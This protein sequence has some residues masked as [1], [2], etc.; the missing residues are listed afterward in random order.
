MLVR[1][2]AGDEELPRWRG[3]LPLARRTTAGG[4]ELLCWRRLGAGEA[5]DLPLAVRSTAGDEELPR[6]RRGRPLARRTVVGG[7]EL[8]RWIE[9]GEASSEG[10]ALLAEVAATSCL[11]SSSRVSNGC[12][13]LLKGSSD[14]AAAE[15][16]VEDPL[17][18]GAGGAEPVDEDGEA[19][20]AS[21]R[22]DAAEARLD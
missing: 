3:G 2:A 4:E 13:V 18:G 9:R 19:V 16:P 5:E 17:D 6:W 21:R 12:A 7:E 8:L 10:R 22:R 11:R 14:L 1:T 15:A 20:A